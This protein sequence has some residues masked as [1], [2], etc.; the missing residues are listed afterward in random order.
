MHSN[1][2]ERLGLRREAERHAAFVRAKNLIR[3]VELRAGESAVA[4]ALCRRSPKIR[5]AQSNRSAVKS[6]CFKVRNFRNE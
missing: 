1:L 6:V 3:P 2:A 5:L 4:A